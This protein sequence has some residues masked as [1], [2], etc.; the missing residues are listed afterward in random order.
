MGTI[1]FEDDSQ[2]SLRSVQ[3]P[4][5]QAVSRRSGDTRSSVDALNLSRPQT[6]QAPS[7][8]QD[9]KTRP[10]LSSRRSSNYGT[11]SGEVSRSSSIN[12]PRPGLSP[13]MQDTFSLPP[14]PS[15]IDDYDASKYASQ[16]PSRASQDTTRS[17]ATAPLET[18]TP[19]ALP[20]R[21]KSK[22]EG[23]PAKVKPAI[24]EQETQ[25]TIELLFA[26]IT[27][28]YTL[29]SAWNIR[30]TLL[31]A[32]KTFLLRPGNPQLQAIR[33]MIQES[34]I[35]AN[36]TDAGLAALVHK[37]REN[38]LPTEEESKKWPAP[39]SG[40]EKEELR[41]K[42]RKLLVERGMPQALTSVMG[43]A[44]SGE[45]LGKVFDCLQIESVARSLIFGLLLQALRAV[46][47]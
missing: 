21:T 40:E 41:I 33:T 2:E 45:A 30:R 13:A 9:L 26:V 20:A 27:E 38:S 14:P 47:Q 1:G 23:R 28:L 43:A 8:P 34:V 10:S 5:P 44:A 35:D 18:E 16:R 17:T 4:K 3:E 24:T 37:I 22:K 36:S 19:P 32:A 29:S 15:M 6:P 25:V 42:A 31:T 11:V 39:L 7:T 46:V 12:L